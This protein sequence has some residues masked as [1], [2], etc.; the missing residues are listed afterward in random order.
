MGSKLLTGATVGF[1]FHMINRF[2]GSMSQVYQLPPELA[3][4][5]PTCLFALLGL[6]FMVSSQIS[7]VN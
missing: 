5:G 7:R 3:A 6:Y 4:I 2:L 1:G